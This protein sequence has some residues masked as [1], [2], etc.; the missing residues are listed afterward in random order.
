MAHVRDQVRQQRLHI[1]AVAVPVENAMDRKRMAQV[2]ISRTAAP[3]GFESATA[4]QAVERH[5]QGGRCC[6]VAAW[7][8]PQRIQRTAAQTEITASPQVAVHD[9]AR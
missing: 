9:T 5:L 1:L 7:T 2:V 6:T 4:H 8:A 3:C